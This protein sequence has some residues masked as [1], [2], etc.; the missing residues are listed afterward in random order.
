M[1][2]INPNTGY[3]FWKRFRP[4]PKAPADALSN[5]PL[6]SILQS[7]SATVTMFRP[8]KP[9]LRDSAAD[10]RVIAAPVVDFNKHILGGWM[11]GDWM[12]RFVW[13]LAV[14]VLLSSL[15]F[16]QAESS[17]SATASSDSKSSDS[18]QPERMFFP[19]D[20]LWGWAQFDLAPP[21]NEIDP[22][23][24]AGNAGQYGGVNAPCSMFARYMLSGMLEVRPFGRGQLRRFMVFGAP[25]FLFGKTIPQTLYTWSPDAIGIEH[26]LGRR[27]LYR[28]GIRVSRDPAFPLRPPRR[29]RYLSWHRRPGQQR[30][31]GTLHDGGRTKVFRHPA[32]VIPVTQRCDGGISQHTGSG[33]ILYN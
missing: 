21:H 27:N 30:S 6:G 24:C 15:S 22:N 16:C 33:G 23:I 26:S 2:G 12:K 1:N 14:P 10:K 18:G 8:R 29:P 17:A 9:A 25:T 19:R 28:Q 20:T 3:G 7:P 5:T 11:I 4:D 31:L 32:M 13:I